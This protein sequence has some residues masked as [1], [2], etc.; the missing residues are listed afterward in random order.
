M[1][2]DPVTQHI[3]DSVSGSPSDHKLFVPV[4]LICR[5]TWTKAQGSYFQ[6]VS[7]VVIQIQAHNLITITLMLLLFCYFW[8]LYNR[9]GFVSYVYIFVNTKVTIQGIKM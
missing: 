1:F 9:R 6:N 7:R 2:G 8:F 3:E 4:P 5:E